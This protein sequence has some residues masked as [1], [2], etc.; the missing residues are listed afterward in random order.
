MEV[1]VR[2]ETWA[3]RYPFRI[4]GYEWTDQELV[5]AEVADGDRRGRGEALGVYYKQETASRLSAEIVA[6]AQRATNVAELTAITAYL[7]PGGAKNAL[8]CALWEL[9]SLQEAMPV[10]RLAGFASAPRPVQTTCTVGAGTP[11]E[12]SARARDFATATALKLKLVGDGADA[13]RVRAVR[14]QRPD[15]WIGVDGNQGFTLQ[16]LHE[17]LPTLIACNINFWNSRFRSVAMK[18]WMTWSRPFPLPPTRACNR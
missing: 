18:I 1:S 10:W 11:E 17:L 12:M 5:V 2:T 8:D 6:A 9:R 14:T 3:F 16:T 7:P 15:A 13:E 4:T